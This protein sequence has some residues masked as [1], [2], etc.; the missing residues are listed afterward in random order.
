M[1]GDYMLEVGN[2]QMMDRAHKYRGNKLRRERNLGDGGRA[3][4]SAG[5]NDKIRWN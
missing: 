3:W 4:N 5:M 1:K 2:P